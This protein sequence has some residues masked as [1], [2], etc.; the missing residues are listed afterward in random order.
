VVHV[1]SSTQNGFKPIMQSLKHKAAN[2]AVIDFGAAEID[3]FLACFPSEDSLEFQF[4]RRGYE[5]IVVIPFDDQAGQAESVGNVIGCL[6]HNI[7]Y[8]VAQVP[9]SADTL[10]ML[11][12]Q[13]SEIIGKHGHEVFKLGSAYMNGSLRAYMATHTDV[14]LREVSD[15]ALL[16]GESQSIFDEN[17]DDGVDEWARHYMKEM[18]AM[19]EKFFNGFAE[20]KRGQLCLPPVDASPAKKKSVKGSVKGESK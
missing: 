18:H 20:H 11:N 1:E 12:S 10:R 15:I 8:V 6:G 2:Y 5:V 4:R 13:F 9:K 14:K 7:N 3:E 17:G 19:W 16:S